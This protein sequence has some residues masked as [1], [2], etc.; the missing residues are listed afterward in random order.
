[1][2][3]QKSSKRGPLDLT[4]CSMKALA[5]R[6]WAERESFNLTG[7]DYG[8]P[9]WGNASGS[10]TAHTY[11][12][13]YFLAGLVKITGARKIVEVGTHQGG[14]ARAMAKALEGSEGG[15]IVTFDITPDGSQLFKQHQSIR[16]Y[17]SDANSEEALNHVIEHFGEPRIDLVFIDA[18]HEFWPTL[19][20]VLIY[21]EICAARF[22][23]LDDITL[24]PG[25]EKLW[26]L[27]GSRYGRKNIIDAT[28]I[29]ENIR[30]PWI[31]APGFGVVRCIPA[32]NKWGKNWP[33]ADLP[34]LLPFKRRS[35]LRRK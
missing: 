7:I 31:T 29:D 17:T 2:K 34:G 28:E 30:R 14:S 16:A 4:N 3:I 26:E 1:M 25:M 13:Y 24:N 6:A 15:K 32:D 27:L 9:H 35:G 10:V 8:K 19:I 18:V 33:G 5:K 20:N 11:P 23:V 12:Y 22:I 21:A